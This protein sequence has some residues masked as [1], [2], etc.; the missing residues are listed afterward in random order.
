MSDVQLSVVIPCR[1]SERHLPALLES[2]AE[3]ETHFHWEVVVV[4][5]RST[6]ATAGTALTFADRLVVRVIKADSRSGPAYAMNAGVEAARG[7]ALVFIG[8]D[9]QTTPG[10]VATMAK[11]LRG[12]DVVAAPQIDLKALND[13][14]SW[15]GLF[16]ERDRWQDDA[17]ANRGFLPWASGTGLGLTRRAFDSVGGFDPDIPTGEDLDISWRLQLRGFTIHLEPRAEVRYRLR[18]TL[19]GLYRQQRGYG[20]GA[21]AL[22][23]KYGAHGMPN[24]SRGI[25]RVPSARAA[26]WDWLWLLR[27]IPRR[28]TRSNWHYWTYHFGYQV[29]CIRGSLRYRVLYL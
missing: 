22:Y 1:N 3:Q 19:I 2:L 14:E 6:D 21:A 8:S 7:Q 28:Q 26:L 18:S 12:H 15:K 16:A 25:P 9:D 10:F 24:I 23:R 20:I 11:A 4:D 17:L 29:G 27:Q 5:N 13:L